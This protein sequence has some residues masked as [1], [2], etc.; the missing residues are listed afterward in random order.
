MK[1][2]NTSVYSAVLFYIMVVIY[3]HIN[4]IFNSLLQKDQTH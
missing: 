3:I 1:L 2:E 4:I